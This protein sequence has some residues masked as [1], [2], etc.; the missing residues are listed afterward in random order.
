[1]NET[2]T[3]IPAEELFEMELGISPTAITTDGAGRKYPLLKYVILAGIV[4][5]AIAIAYRISIKPQS[6]KTRSHA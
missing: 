6:L 5:G 2:F 3:R 1:M 4:L